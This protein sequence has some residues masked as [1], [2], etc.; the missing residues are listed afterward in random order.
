[1]IITNQ[2]F[3]APPTKKHIPKPKKL[4]HFQAVILAFGTT[5]HLVNTTTLGLPLLH[6]ATRGWAEAFGIRESRTSTTTS[7]DFNVSANKRSAAP[8]WPGYREIKGRWYPDW[9]KISEEEEE[10]VMV[11]G[12]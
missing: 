5:S 8:M 4:T 6:S 10:G 1:M 9:D 12:V 2:Y 7:T 3:F 11:V